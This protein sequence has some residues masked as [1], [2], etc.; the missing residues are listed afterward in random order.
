[1]RFEQ[2]LS[3]AS[4]RY[5]DRIAVVSDRRK[6]TYRELEQLALA[7]A[8][9]LKAMGAGPGE[10]TVVMAP[11]SLAF[12]VGYF[13]ALMSGATVTCLAPSAPWREWE[14]ILAVVKPTAAF[15]PRRIGD[16]DI[17]D[18]IG[19]LLPGEVLWVDDLD[20]PGWPLRA[21]RSMIVDR[22]PASTGIYAFTSGSTG[23]PKGAS[24]RTDTLFLTAANL[25]HIVLE[26]EPVISASTFPMYNMGG[27][28]MMLPVL[29]GGGTIVVM[30]GFS[31]PKLVDLI[32]RH[33]VNFAVATPAMAELLFIKGDL[34]Q[35]DLSA[36]NR[37]LL[38]AAP[39][40]NRLCRQLARQLNT[41][42]F[43]A[44]G[45][46]EIPGAWLTTKADTPVE[47]IGPFVGWPVDGYELSI[48]DD[49]NNQVPDGQVGEVCVRT[50]YMLSEYI[51][52]AAATAAALDREGRMHTGDLGR[53]RPDGG[54]II[55]GRKKEMYIRGGFNVYPREVEQTL[56][57]HP[58]VD[59]AAVHGV[60]DPVLGEK[61]FA[62]VVPVPGAELSVP[63]LR[64]FL[65]ER[66][67]HYK[68]PDTYRFVPE[69]PMTAAGKV[70]KPALRANAALTPRGE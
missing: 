70:D 53:L 36:F 2:L 54:L 13:G 14:G 51:G 27:I 67:S 39:I 32:E 23:R 10:A 38:C 11:N 18:E 43:I 28:C 69:L 5:G 65:A 49:D 45:L 64:E 15:M 25:L 21:D 56:A 50:Q 29:M 57:E 68:L 66:L 33:G 41:K 9:R 20:L 30:D 1:M 26:D 7:C 42:V 8:D 52:D 61:G 58:G 34:E 6:V 48:L 4:D 59:L 17:E 40:S 16:R 46:T 12:L 44:Y 24:H 19:H 55:E 63:Q 47:E 31:A 37:I 60:D 35:H 3:D 62:W 22:D